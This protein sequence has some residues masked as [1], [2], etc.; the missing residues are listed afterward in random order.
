MLELPGFA[1]S[2]EQND[3]SASGCV[4]SGCKACRPLGI[5]PPPTPQ[6]DSPSRDTVT[7]S[8]RHHRIQ[9]TLNRRSPWRTNVVASRGHNH[10]AEGRAPG[11]LALR[12][13]PRH[14]GRPAGH[15]RDLTAVTVTRGLAVRLLYLLGPACIDSGQ[16]KED[17][18]GQC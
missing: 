10:H 15:R 6:V 14:R 1:D 12:D 18:K 5:N 7:E 2:A 13:E 11:P 9:Q 3:T 16:R 17:A 4:I 8:H